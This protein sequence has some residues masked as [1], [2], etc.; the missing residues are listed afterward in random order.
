MNLRASRP[1]SDNYPLNCNN[2]KEK[3]GKKHE[4]VALYFV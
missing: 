2:L 1:R 3:N 4:V